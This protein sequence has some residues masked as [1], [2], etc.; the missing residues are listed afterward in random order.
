MLIVARNEQAI[1]ESKWGKVN[2]IADFWDESTERK[3]HAIKQQLNKL[4]PFDV[5]WRGSG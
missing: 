5:E 4:A 3:K 2:I 1:E